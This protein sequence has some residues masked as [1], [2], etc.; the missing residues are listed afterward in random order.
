MATIEISDDELQRILI[1]PA[2]GNQSKTSTPGQPVNVFESGMQ[3]PSGTETRLISAG[4]TVDK[5]VSGVQNLFADEQR[6]A[7]IA[8]EQEEKDR[9]FSQL[10]EQRPVSTAVGEALPFFA[11]PLRIGSGLL[12]TG[13]TTASKV[14]GFKNVAT[15]AD[16]VKDSTAADAVITGGLIGGATYDD[17]QSG[18]AIEGGLLGLA[19][20]LGGR[21]LGRIIQPVQTRLEGQS[22]RLADW[23]KSKGYKLLPSEETGSLPLKQLEASMQSS[24]STSAPIQAVKDFN[25]KKHNQIALNSIGEDGTEI[26]G[27]KLDAAHKK[28]GEEFNRL[29]RG[30]EIKL[31]YGEEGTIL[32]RINQNLERYGIDSID[33]IDGG[34]KIVEKTVLNKLRD[35]DV[36]TG[37]N[38]QR[39]QS[40]ANNKSRRLL[41]VIGNASDLEKGFLYAA[42]KESLDDAAERSLGGAKLTAFK[43]VRRKWKNKL[44]IESPNVVNT[45]TADISPARLAN[46]LNRIDKFGFRFGRDTS[47]LYQLGRFGQAFK[48]IADSGTAT[49]STVGRFE[50]TVGDTGKLL[51]LGVAGAGALSDAQLNNI[52][53]AL[54]FGATAPAITSSLFNLG[55][56]GY[57]AGGGFPLKGGLLPPITENI[58]PDLLQTVRSVSGRAVPA[59]NLLGD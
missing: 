41:G 15:V 3:V 26:T 8:R 46:T 53:P 25:Q 52:L 59:F 32:D 23:A 1:P 11:L 56:R 57:V 38:Y 24:P 17:N 4:R 50:Q 28:L 45:G 14:P 48:D 12:G 36:I 27:E 33:E 55:S 18:Q 30:E 20:D 16:K 39:L 54:A 58:T 2:D 9:L 7:E 31:D 40:L 47:D 51:G 13:L 35:G 22:K 42:I 29:T 21:F 19:G 6:Q 34:V 44:A 49:R 10:S 37:E 5:L 43:D